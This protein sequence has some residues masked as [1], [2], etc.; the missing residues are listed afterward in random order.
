VTV[1]QSVFSR[2]CFLILG[3]ILVA[4][5]AAAGV[6]AWRVRHVNEFTRRW[7]VRE[8]A[9]RFAS[10]VSLEKVKVGAFPELVVTGENLDIQYRNRADLPPLIHVDKFVFHLGLL[11]LFEVPH[12]IR[13]GRVEKL[14]ITIPPRG[15]RV[16]KPET[17]NEISPGMAIR[18]MVVDEIHCVNAELVH[19]S[20]DP[21]K[22]PLDWTIH[23]L[24]LRA[25]NVDKPFHFVGTLTNAKP[26]GEIATEGDFGPWNLGE[27]GATSVAGSYKFTNANLGPLPGIAGTL[28][29]TGEYRGQLDQL[30]VD[31]ETN[32]PDF[33]LDGVGKP[34]PLHTEY[35]ATVDGTNGDTFLH[36]V[37]ATLMHSLIL[38]E[39][40]VVNVK[41]KG[42][43]IA[44]EVS[45]PS[46][47]IEDLL[48]LAMKSDPPLMT[49]AAKIK[50][51]LFL[52]PGKAK[53][54][55]KTILDGQVGLDDAR[56]SSPEVRAKL[57]ALSRTAEGH[58]KDEDAGSAISDLRGR[59]HLEKGVVQFSDLTFSVPG[60]TIELAGTYEI[61]GGS[62]DFKGHLRTQA[63]LSQMTTGAKS[64]FLKA[65]DPF[66]KKHGAG[67]DLPITISGKRDHVTFGVSMFHKT[68]GGKVEEQ[69]KTDS[70]DAKKN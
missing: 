19:L 54:L 35:S 33:S 52:P 43:D 46:A 27:P 70:N 51:K 12:H 23:D 36:P 34:I 13:G 59:F 17:H 21:A 53:V 44:L 18:E 22:D 57:E 11:G 31:G 55:E 4:L 58:P 41:G 68:I 8:L 5:L 10:N 62:L 67:A 48:S 64:F 32:T 28:S 26:V 63:K 56:W 61:E 30:E 3:A 7:M 24:I 39:G 47:R 49:G 6:I 9:Q 45:A 50:A 42:H 29:S 69:K 2:R 37:Q 15:Q 38:A 40:K 60:A 16:K 20:K 1:R 65:F 25:V 66:F 14:V